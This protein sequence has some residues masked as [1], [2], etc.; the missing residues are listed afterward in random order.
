[1]TGSGRYT[2]L[3]GCKH[4]QKHVEVVLQYTEMWKQGLQR[5]YYG[6]NKEFRLSVSGKCIL[7]DNTIMY[8]LSTRIH[9]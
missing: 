5:M 3:Q 6:L 8:I 2:L 4:K 1:M 9:W 7:Y